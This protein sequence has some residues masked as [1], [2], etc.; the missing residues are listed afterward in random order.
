LV[1]YPDNHYTDYTDV[2][3]QLEWDIQDEVELDQYEFIAYVQDR[4]DWR[5][6]WFGANAG[7][8]TTASA[9]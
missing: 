1:R 8:I 9:R 4:W 3:D 7:Y 5:D 2:L 6:Q